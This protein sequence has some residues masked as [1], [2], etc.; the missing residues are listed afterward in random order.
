MARIPTAGAGAAGSNDS[1]TLWGMF[2]VA[3]APGVPIQAVFQNADLVG[4]VVQ[5]GLTTLQVPRAGLYQVQ[6]CMKFLPGGAPI[7]SYRVIRLWT[8]GATQLT[9]C[10][11]IDPDACTDEEFWCATGWF[12]SPGSINN[13]IVLHIESGSADI[14]GANNQHVV[15]LHVARVSD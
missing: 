3:L 10:T 2:P 13:D 7:L 5:A 9:G 8:N 14:V 12:R 6:A 1:G 11:R 15:H 4:T